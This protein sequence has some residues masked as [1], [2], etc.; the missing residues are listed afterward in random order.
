V[1]HPLVTKNDNG[2]VRALNQNF[3]FNNL[4]SIILQHV[5]GVFQKPSSGKVKTL[6]QRLSNKK[7]VSFS[8]SCGL[9]CTGLSVL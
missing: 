1:G 7:K 5:P 9:I 3:I 4:L 6:K 2:A 8:S